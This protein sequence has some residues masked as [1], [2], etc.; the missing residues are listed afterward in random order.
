[1]RSL[2]RLSSP[3]A[4]TLLA[5]FAL[6]TVAG[7]GDEDPDLGTYFAVEGYRSS[8]CM[9]VD[10]KLA[11]RREIR[12]FRS[13]SFTDMPGS[14]RGLQ[15]YYRRHSLEFFATGGEHEIGML[16]AVDDRLVSFENALAAQFPGVDLD[17]SAALMRDPALWERVQRAAGAFIL[18]PMVEFARTHGTV[19]LG[20]TNLVLLHDIVATGWATNPNILG[21]AISPA[22]LAVL[23]AGGGPDA[24]FWQGLDLPAD[25]TPMLFLHAGMLRELG[26]SNP[27]ARDAVVAHEFGHTAGLVHEVGEDD[28]DNLMFPAIDGALSACASVLL[29]DQL[30]LMRRNLGVGPAAP[31]ASQALTARRQT[32]HPG[33]QPLRPED[34]PALFAGDRRPLLRVLAPL[35][36]RSTPVD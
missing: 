34:L 35:L 22:L 33:L 9:S 24:A 11:G 19:G 3:R 1:V 18:R 16:Y 6:A 28:F 32:T 2:P 12:M 30:A 5:L 10:D 17:D 23:G 13:G 14:T 26:Q 29:D 25:F 8:R 4:L 27:E 15:R 20:A 31:V 21:L 36:H 7:C